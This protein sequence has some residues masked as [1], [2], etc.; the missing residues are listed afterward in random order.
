MIT[1]G[2]NSERSYLTGWINPRLETRRE[3]ALAFPEADPEAFLNGA[4]DRRVRDLFRVNRLLADRGET[5]VKA[6]SGAIAAAQSI[7]TAYR[8]G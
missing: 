2:W 3:V 5:P 4:D 1:N 8:K 6:I 7:L